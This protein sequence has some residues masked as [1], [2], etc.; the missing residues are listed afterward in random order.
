MRRLE[1]DFSSSGFLAFQSV[2][3]LVELE[4]EHKGLFGTPRG[5]SVLFS[6]PKG[7]SRRIE[8]S[9]E[10]VSF[11]P[12]SHVHAYVSRV[13]FSPVEKR[14]G[15]RFLRTSFGFVHAHPL[16]LSDGIPSVLALTGFETFTT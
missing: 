8:A 16:A 10:G 4:F 12:P 15:C 3:R 13:D 14:Q 2:K 6:L 5:F 9:S 11:G 1:A 7:S